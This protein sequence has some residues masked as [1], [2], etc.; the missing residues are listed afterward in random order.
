MSPQFFERGCTGLP[1]DFVRGLGLFVVL[2]GFERWLSKTI[3][4][5]CDLKMQLKASLIEAYILQIFWEACPH[6]PQ[7]VPFALVAPKTFL[8]LFQKVGISVIS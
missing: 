2:Y 1:S 8:F 6:T 3:F 4:Q 5:E 7:V